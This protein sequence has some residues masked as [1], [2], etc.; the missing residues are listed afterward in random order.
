MVYTGGTDKASIGKTIPPTLGYIRSRRPDSFQVRTSI[1]RMRKSLLVGIVIATFAGGLSTG[2]GRGGPSP[3][4]G[5]TE[6][7][8][9]KSSTPVVTPTRKVLLT[10]SWPGGTRELSRDELWNHPKA[11]DLSLTDQAAH[12]G[13]K[14]TFHV[15]PMPAVLEGITF[16]N[17]ET[18]EFDSLDGFSASLDP[19]QV[20][21]TDK[22]KARAYLAIED[23]SRPWPKSSDEKPPPGPLYLVWENPERS[24]IGQEQ[25]PFQLRSFSVKASVESRFPALVPLPEIGKD[26]TIYRGYQAFLKNCFSCH[27]FNGEGTSRMGP[28][29][30]WPHSPIEYFQEEYFRKLVRDPQSLRS[31][32]GSRMSSFSHEMLP[33]PV[34]DDLIAYLRH[35]AHHRPSTLNP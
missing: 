33:E 14:I 15:V 22:D 11:T 18:L 23:P 30:N 12:S 7:P 35:K 34:L 13:Q 6:T 29:L 9:V 20:L 2:C 17:G 32:K 26:D 8:P 19:A 27:T 10:V 5:A 24:D 1:S 4:L 21:N 28:D 3:R 16:K 25:W 31:W